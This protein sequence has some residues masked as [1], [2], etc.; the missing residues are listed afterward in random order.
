MELTSRDSFYPVAGLL[1]GFLLSNFMTIRCYFQKCAENQYHLTRLLSNSTELLAFVKKSFALV[2]QN[3]MNKIQLQ[4]N[5]QRLWAFVE[6]FKQQLLTYSFHNLSLQDYETQYRAVFFI[7][8][9]LVTYSYLT[10]NKMTVI[11]QEQQEG[12]PV[13]EK[14][15]EKEKPKPKTGKAKGRRVRF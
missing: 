11:Q 8:V 9:L 1:I 6:P 15:E 2:T 13:E 3:I 5:L 12:L 7:V 14:Q 10:M 4:A